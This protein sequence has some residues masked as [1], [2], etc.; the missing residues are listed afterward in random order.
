LAALAVDNWSIDSCWNMDDVIKFIN[1]QSEKKNIMSQIP[2]FSIIIPT[3][4]RAN[5]FKDALR[6]VLQQDFDD[7]EVLV[8]DNSTDDKT[9]VIIDSFQNTPKLKTFRTDGNLSMP[10][11][12]EFIT[13]KA[14]GRYVLILTDRSVLKQHSLNSIYEAISNSADEILVCAWRWTLFDDENNCEYADF[15]IIEADTTI[16]LLSQEIAERFVN[17]REGYPYDLP[18]TLNSCYRNDIATL[19]RNRYGALFLPISPDFTSAFL[20]LAHTKHVLFLDTALFISQGL[21]VSNGGQASDSF[22]AAENYL[23]TLG[24]SDYY[25]HVPI[26]IPLVESLIFEDFLVIQKLAGGELS[27]ININWVEYFTRCYKEIINKT[28]LDKNNIFLWKQALNTTDKDIQDTVKKRL[29]A[30]WWKIL[31]T[32]LKKIKIVNILVKFTKNHAFLSQ[33]HRSTTILE[34]AGHRPND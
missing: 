21:Q 5:L 17:R 11:H 4:N 34:V 12:W 31:K 3:R 7:F 13:Q 10:Q 18:R 15:P 23:N 29:S 8:S 27:N 32:Q 25:T 33:K 16:H 9:Q 2:F 22:S 19:I 20:L 6:S 26:K 1:I 14:Q 24:I 28:S 30:L